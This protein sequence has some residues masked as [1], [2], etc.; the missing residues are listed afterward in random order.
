MFKELSKIAHFHFSMLIKPSSGY[1]FF[2]QN[3]H[4]CY[5]KTNLYFAKGIAPL[6][7]SVQQLFICIPLEQRRKRH[8]L[9]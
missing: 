5:F 1:T 8:S 9:V 7:D 4:I 3:D 6:E 2:V